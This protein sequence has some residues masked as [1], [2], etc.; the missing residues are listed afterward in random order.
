MNPI[1]GANNSPGVINSFPLKQH[2]NNGYI[3]NV[4]MAMP[5]QFYPS[6]NS[7]LFSSARNVMSLSVVTIFQVS[8]KMSWRWPLCSSASVTR[9]LVR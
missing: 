3:S 8:I 2:T 6:A 5:S 7:S 4:R 9:F 1:V